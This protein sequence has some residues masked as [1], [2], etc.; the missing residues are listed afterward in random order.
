MNPL[1]PEPLPPDPLPV[2]GQ[3]LDEASTAVKNA[4]AMALATVDPD[5]RP[6]ARMVICRGFDQKAGWLVFYSETT[7]RKGLAL[8]AHPRAALVFHW[9][10][11][12]RQVRVEG[13]VTIAP[14]EQTDAYWNSRPLDARIAAVASMQSH[15][16]ASRAALLDKVAAA[17]AESGDRPR[18]PDRWIGYR[19][20]ADTIELWSGQPARVHDRAIWTRRLVAS[21]EGFT[22]SP[23]ISTLLQP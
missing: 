6:S 5:G 22:G 16:I 14:D 20:W 15:P 19:V 1:L 13:P 3:W 12:E 8:S 11:L 2:V 18:R 17:A 7:S 23:W 21:P 10:A 9:S 4:T